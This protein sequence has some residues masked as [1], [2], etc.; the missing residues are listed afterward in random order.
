[1]HASRDPDGQE[2]ES[3]SLVLEHRHLQVFRSTPPSHEVLYL[4]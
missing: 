4:A 2:E 3:L 1:M